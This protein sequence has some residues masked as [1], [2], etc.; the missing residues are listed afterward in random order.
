[1]EMI[2]FHT[3]G[4]RDMFWESSTNFW[5]RLGL[6]GRRPPP[7]T[8]LD[9]QTII[10][11]G[12]NRGIGREVSIDLALRGARVV[13]ACRDVSAGKSVVDEIKQR[14]S[15]AEVVIHRLDLKSLRSVREFADSIS[16][17]EARIDCLV[18]NAGIIAAQREETEDKLESHMAVNY[19]G[20]ACLSMLL[21]EKIRTTSDSP[22]IV[23]VSS[24]AHGIN[25]R[26]DVT[27]LNNDKSYNTWKAYSASKLAILMFS[28]EL[29]RRQ[30]DVRVYVV[31]P[32]YSPTNLFDQLPWFMRVFVLN[33]IASL[34]M[35]QVKASADSVLHAVLHPAEEYDPAYNFLYDGEVKEPR[36]GALIRSDADQLWNETSRILDIKSMLDM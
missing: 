30:Q 24:M 15:A 7:S 9:D 34:I 25:P 36:S 1:M 22:R 13:I 14:D 31:D 17:S 4:A 26:L 2:R 20:A 35:R 18:N 5:S 11:T 19:F 10:V 21:L 32:G 28:R 29:A 3:Y 33:P 27:D 6:V 8:R 23:S 16:K 12:G